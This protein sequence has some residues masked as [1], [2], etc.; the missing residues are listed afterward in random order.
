MRERLKIIERL[1]FPRSLRERG[2][3]GGEALKIGMLD[4][5]L[6]TCLSPNPSP[7]REGLKL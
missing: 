6:M 3:R 7:M 4:F 5:G 2:I 1:N